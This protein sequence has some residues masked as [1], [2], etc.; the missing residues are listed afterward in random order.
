MKRKSNI[1]VGMSGGVDSSLT[2]MLLKQKYKVVG[3]ILKL[4]NNMVDGFTTQACGNEKALDRAKKAAEEVNV[5]LHVIDCSE[6]FFNKTL[7]TCWIAFEQGNTPNPCH[8]CNSVVKFTELLKAADKF[9]AKKIATGHY[10][11]ISSD[12]KNRPVLKRGADTNKDQSYFLSG[13]SQEILSRTMFPLGGMRKEEVRKLADLYNLSSV[14]LKESQDLCFT[15]PEG[16]FSNAL[17]NRFSGKRIS[18]VFLNES[19]TVL[20][21]HNGIHQYTI[22]Q[23]RGLGFATGSRVKIISIN[24]SNGIIVVSDKK[25]AACSETCRAT[26][27]KWSREPMNSGDTVTAQVRYRQTPTEAVITHTERESIS[28]SFDKPVFGVTPGQVLV[29]YKDNCVQGSGIISR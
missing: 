13:L 10:A 3:V 11:Q 6:C 26:S 2:A 24:P 21:R 22:G 28:I 15:G 14:K 19:G 23:R 1:I 7:K 16:H 8:I 5:P 27:F 4:H 20:G 9:G 12:Q 29:L 17:F 25:E 18:G